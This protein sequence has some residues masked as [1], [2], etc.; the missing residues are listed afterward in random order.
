M[1]SYTSLSYLALLLKFRKL[2]DARLSKE[3]H[4]FKVI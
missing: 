3:S 2:R 1:L 4:F